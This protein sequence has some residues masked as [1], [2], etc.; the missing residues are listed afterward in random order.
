MCTDNLIKIKDFKIQIIIKKTLSE[1][2]TK[3]ESREKALYLMSKLICSDK[4]VHKIT[5][6]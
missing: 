1:I 4:H 6:R 3:S 2:I 5:L